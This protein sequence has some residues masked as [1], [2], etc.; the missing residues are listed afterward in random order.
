MTT[1]LSNFIHGK[2]VAAADG[3][4]AGDSPP[5]EPLASAG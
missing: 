2:K 4:T 1:E 3:Q 5:P